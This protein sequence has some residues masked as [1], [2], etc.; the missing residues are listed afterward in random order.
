MAITIF[1]FCAEDQYTDSNSF[2]SVIQTLNE[3]YGQEK[4]EIIS[5]EN[6]HVNDCVGCWNCW[7]KTPG[8]CVHND[9]MIFYYE[10][11]MASD[12]VVFLFPAK[13]GFLTGH[14]KTFIDRLIPLY[15]PYIDIIHGEMMH[16]YRYE[17]YPEMDFYYEEDGL[18][19]IENQII[20]DYC[21][22]MAHH[23][24]ITA[25]RWM[26]KEHKVIR[27][28]LEHREPQ[29][30]MPWQAIQGPNR[31]K[32]IIYN[33][34]P[35]GKKSNSLILIQ[36]IVEGMKSKGLLEDAYEV[37][38]LALQRNHDLWAEDFWNHTRHI[39]VFPLYVHSMPGIVMKFFEKLTPLQEKDAVQ[40]AFFVQSGFMESYQSTYLLPYLAHL[41]SRL[42]AVYGGTLIKGSMEGIQIRPEKS[43]TKLFDQVKTLGA[44]YIEKGVF[45]YEIADEF[46]KPYKLTGT[47]KTIYKSLKWTGIMNFYW[48]MQLKKNGVMKNRFDQP[49]MFQK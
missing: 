30:D 40:M 38:H 31:G 36:H 11:I 46:K 47:W 4:T 13:N 26:I 22:R 1:N 10:K 39:F 37:R 34:S 42:N 21:Y 19:P 25:G 5:V 29:Q 3:T 28:T 23:F 33:G 7:V 14:V 49:Y 20:E 44:S 15:H 27:K 45:D 48:N 43:L 2:E 18:T 35:R 12:K 9:D 41:P 17:K 32:V 6:A 16:V 8:V 24:R